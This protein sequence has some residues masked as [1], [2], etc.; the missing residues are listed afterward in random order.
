MS[1]RP[2][3]YNVAW[4]GKQV[5]PGITK[6]IELSKAR[7]GTRS[8]GAYVNRNMNRNVTPPIK[9]VHATGNAWDCDYGIKKTEKENEALARVIWDF[10]LHN[11]ETLGISLVNWY[12]FGTYGATYKSSRGE[13]KLGVRI[14]SSD[15]ESAG[16][17]QGTPTWLHIELD[18]AMSKD[19]AKFAKAWASI[20]YP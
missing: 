13:S 19:A 16:S 5:S 14:H 2:Y 3:P 8:L 1:P 15:A 4:D 11:S 10:L 6:L 17:Y 18:V 9:S 7:W 20:P 12:A